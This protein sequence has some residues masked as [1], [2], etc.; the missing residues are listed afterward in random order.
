M[1]RALFVSICLCMKY[2]TIILSA[3]FSAISL[4]SFAKDDIYSQS[5]TATFAS[6]EDAEQATIRI[7]PFPEN[8]KIA[9]TTRWDDT[10]VA[11]RLTAEMLAERN[12]SAS[13]YLCGEHFSES[14]KK[15]FNKVL[16]LGGALGAH[17]INHPHLENLLPNDIFREMALERAFI[18]SNFDRCV[19]SFVLPYGTMSSPLDSKVAWYVGMSM[20]HAGFRFNPDS[21]IPFKRRYNLSMP[22]YHSYTFGIDDRN[23]QRSKMESNMKT[24]RAR[25]KAKAEP[26]ITLGIHSWQNAEARKRLGQYIDEFKSDDFWY[27]NANQYVAYRTHALKS[28]AKKFA[29]NGNTATFELRRIPATNLG[30]DIAVSI[31]FSKKPTSVRVGG[32][33]IS[34][35]NGYYNIE[36]YENRKTPKKIGLIKFDENKGEMLES[37][38]FKGLKFA[39]DFDR[40]NAIVSVKTSGD[41]WEKATGLRVRWIV[42]P[43]FDKPADSVMY[44]GKTTMTKKLKPNKMKGTEGFAKAFAEGNMLVMAQCD[45]I[46]EGTPARVWLTYVDKREVADSNGVRDRALQLGDFDA[47]QNDVDTFKKFSMPETTLTDFAGC[48][49][50]KKSNKAMREFLID[51]NGFKHMSKYKNKEMSYLICADF[52]AERAGEHI[53]YSASKIKQAYVNGKLVNPKGRAKVELQKGKNRV[54]VVL[55]NTALKANGLMLAIKDGNKMLPVSTPEVK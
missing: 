54:L 5:I 1:R 3:I 48:K 39:F 18:E 2:S 9:Y 50:T 53:M 37:N 51:F 33:E 47:S 34:D 6:P 29:V 36:H 42:P 14:H 25:I 13:I 44:N 22:M 17:C 19:V 52:Q 23:P 7:L 20:V 26:V 28:Q 27:C 32:K 10:N 4:T 12:M 21:I 8:K 24:A 45:F 30:D 31:E 55:D 41:A 15:A 43:C 38:K 46:Y 35:K 49:W 16:A 40:E 11:H